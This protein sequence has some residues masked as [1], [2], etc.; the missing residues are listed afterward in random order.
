MALPHILGDKDPKDLTNGWEK[1]WAYLKEM[2]SAIDYYPSGT[3]ATMKE[4]SE[5]T[6]D[7]IVST[8][9]WD[10]NPRAIGVVPRCCSS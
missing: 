9:G 8:L 3:T 1:T 4:L 6:R 2:D 10:I 7:M 5:G